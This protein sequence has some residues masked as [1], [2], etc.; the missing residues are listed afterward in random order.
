MIGGRTTRDKGEGQKMSN[1]INVRKCLLAVAAAAV[2]L[3]LGLTF[4]QSA[5]AGRSAAL[6]SAIV[7]D[8]RCA[9]YRMIPPSW[10]EQAKAN[11]KVGYSHTSH[12]SQ[13]VTGIEALRSKPGSLFD[14]TYSGWSLQ[15]GIFLNDYWANDHAADLGHN[16][17]LSWRDATI[18]MLDNPEDDRNVV[19]WSW[20]GGV[21]DNTAEGISAYLRA[22][23]QLEAKYPNVRFVYM[24]GHLDGSGVNGNLNIR[25]NQIRRY[26]R[27]NGKVLFDF[28][29][30]ESF[31]P[32]GGT[33]YMRLFAND[34]CDYDADGDGNPE[35]N[36]AGEWITAHPDSRLTRLASRCGECAHSQ[37]LNCVRKGGAFWWLMARL[38][39]W[40]G[41]TTP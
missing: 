20:C 28:A 7:I 16:G 4:R 26:C 22:M 21:S 23:N 17:D 3:L 31:A 40:D 6:A 11:L 24:T 39:G 34:A 1:R 19:M 38:A 12:G 41:V 10:I 37:A 18:I 8:H 9:D 14:F 25:N 29:D 35:S 27:N 33:N 32:T 36:W 15:P 2:V 13:L 30:I 5:A